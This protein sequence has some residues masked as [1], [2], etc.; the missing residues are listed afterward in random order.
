MAPAGDLVRS[1][2]LLVP[3]HTRLTP[4]LVASLAMG[5]I[6]EVPVFRPLKI[7]FLPTGSELIPAG[8]KPQRGQNIEVNSL[9]LSGYLGRYGAEVQVFSI[10]KDDPVALER[11]LDQALCRWAAERP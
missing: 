5:G 1:G 6:T 10:T 2:A 7:A 8:Q 3:A 9:L 4:E 11:T